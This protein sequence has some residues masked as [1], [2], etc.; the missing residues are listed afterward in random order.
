MHLL[1]KA[2]TVSFSLTFFA[3]M[4][5]LGSLIQKDTEDPE[6]FSTSR[7]YIDESGNKSMAGPIF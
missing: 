6:M 5:N 1:N 4:R 7:V 2:T 3:L